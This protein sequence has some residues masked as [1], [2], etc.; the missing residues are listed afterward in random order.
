VVSRLWVLAHEL[1]PFSA[2]ERYA[3]IVRDAAERREIETG[4]RPHHVATYPL[5][6][7]P[8]VRLSA[9]SASQD[10]R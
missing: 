2:I 8:Y 9:R 10:S 6:D 7:V 4:N 1:A 3:S 5:A